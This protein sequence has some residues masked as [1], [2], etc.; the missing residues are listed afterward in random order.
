MK[1]SSHGEQG[2]TD[3]NVRVISMRANT[4][5]NDATLEELLKVVDYVQSNS[6]IS[7]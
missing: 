4:L 3:D 2:Y 7:K 1:K 6:L 5:K